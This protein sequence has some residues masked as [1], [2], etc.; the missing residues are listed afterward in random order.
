M[1][2]SPIIR[3]TPSQSNS[4]AAGSDGMTLLFDV[5]DFKAVAEI[6]K[7]HRRVQLSD[8][9]KAE[10]AE[11]CRKM[12]EDRLAAQDQPKD[13]KESAPVCDFAPQGYS[14]H[15]LGESAVLGV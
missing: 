8:A 1:P 12:T 7:P 10:L 5:A 4:G 9:R 15:L 6:V 3:P 14:E 11:R 13:R 2:L